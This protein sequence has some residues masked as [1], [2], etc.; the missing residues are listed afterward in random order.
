[1]ADRAARAAKAAFKIGT[2]ISPDAPKVSQCLAESHC[3]AC[4]TKITSC[5]MICGLCTYKCES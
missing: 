3:M 2:I 1:V 4:E 5:V